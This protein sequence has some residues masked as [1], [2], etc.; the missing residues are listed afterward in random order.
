[1][2]FIQL[3]LGTLLSLSSLTLFASQTINTSTENHQL[4]KKVVQAY[5]GDSLL[6]LSSYQL[7]D[8]YKSFREGQSYSADEIDLEHARAQLTVDLAKQRKDFKW[9]TG[10]KDS[11]SVRQQ[12]FDG[13]QGYR[14]NHSDKTLSQVPNLNF[15]STERHYSYH[16]DTAL[17][18][19][20]KDKETQITRLDDKNL[21]GAPHFQVL[22]E[23]QGYPKLTLLINQRDFRI[24]K[25]E[26]PHWSGKVF[27]Y[28][29]SDYRNVDGLLY[30]NSVFVTRGGAP[31]SVLTHREFI[32]NLAVKETFELPQDYRQ[33]GKGIDFS[34]MQAKQIDDKLYLVGQDWGFSIFLDAG[35][36]FVGAGGY[37]DLSKRLAFVQDKYN[38]QKP[39][40]YL[41]V[42]HHHLDHLGGMKEA[43][44]LGAI[45]VTKQQHLA[46]IESIVGETIAKERLLFVEEQLSLANG[47]VQAINYPNSHAEYSLVTYFNNEQVLFSAD[48]YFSRDETG[49][50]QGYQALHGL[51]KRLES[52][53]VSPK[54]FAA[55][56]SFRV[57][58]DQDFVHSLANMRSAQSI[59]PVNWTICPQ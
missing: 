18:L 48:T 42:S 57:L 39:L 50:P 14:L 29:F 7:T 40:K 32:P 28:R 22:L 16:L 51:Q 52:L 37:K 24:A 5:G 11:F 34:A 8:H 53:E 15:I 2:R 26:R 45:L 56:H 43:F 3:T 55:A 4:I 47:Q 35:D 58:T 59:C 46:T 41:V 30:A 13:N 38:L 36:Y 33:A 6:A 21:Y 44:D 27:S 54:H 19:L 12:L 20:I 49:S 31:Y 25:L 17:A 10:D 23:R 1:M 9:L